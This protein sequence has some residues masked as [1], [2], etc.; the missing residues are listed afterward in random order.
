MSSERSLFMS[1]LSLVMMPLFILCDSFRYWFGLFLSVCS[2]LT[3]PKSLAALSALRDGSWR[4]GCYWTQINWRSRGAQGNAAW[5]PTDWKFCRQEGP[6]LGLRPK[7]VTVN[8]S[9]KHYTSLKDEVMSE[10]SMGPAGWIFTLLPADW[11]TMN[12]PGNILIITC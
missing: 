10:T 5:D 1:L 8:I 4:D 12:Q 9:E 11:H 6:F 3:P 2:L 7:R